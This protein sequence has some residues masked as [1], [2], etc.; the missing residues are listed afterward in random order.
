[1][2][3]LQADACNESYANVKQLIQ[4]LKFPELDR[5]FTFTGDLK[6]V[7]IMLGISSASCSFPC[8]YCEGAKWAKNAKGKMAVTNKFGRFVRGRERTLGN[9]KVNQ[10]NFIVKGGVNAKKYKNCVREVISLWDNT[11]D[12]VSV[13]SRFPIDPLHVL[14]L[15]IV[16][17]I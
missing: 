9:I 12:H 14:L 2:I 15:G 11:M 4:L 5:E 13:L 1:M 10:R 6:M 17:F 7:N 3:I 16:L 8:P